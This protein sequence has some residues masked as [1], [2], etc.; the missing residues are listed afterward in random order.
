MIKKSI[1]TT[2]ETWLHDAV[3]ML[4]RSKVPTPRL[5]AEVLLAH[6]LGVNRTWLIAHANDNIDD[7]HALENAN[8]LLAKRL[9]RVPIAY[10]TNHKEFYGRSFFVDESVLIPRPESEMM[11]DLLKEIY[12]EGS[13][14]KEEGRNSIRLIDVGTGS[15]CLGITAK[16]E[17]PALD[18]TLC[19]ISDEALA[20][21]HKNATTLK[22]DVAIAKSDLLSSF[23]IL[24]SSFDVILANLP[25]VDANW[26]RSPETDHEP[27]L[28][29]FADD[30]GLD[31]IKKCI[32]QA[33]RSLQKDGYLILEADPCQH[34]EIIRCSKQFGFEVVRVQDYIVALQLRVA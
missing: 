11:I 4:V 20:I 34:D 24:P 25:Y 1:V 15:G 19:D 23:I 31:L 9:Q 17:L 13:R 14:K 29:L 3:E 6:A 33:Q 8:K 12:G 32:Q 21:A 22:A 5:D 7:A 30:N 26:E 18:V 2:I 28:A 16:L 10:L 27:S